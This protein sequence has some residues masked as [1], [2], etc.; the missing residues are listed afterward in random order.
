MYITDLSLKNF[1]NYKNTALSFSKKFNII[2]GMNAQGKTNIIE[3]IYLCASGRS[4]RTS[5]DYEL[6]NIN[7]DKFGVYVS[8]TRKNRYTNISM[9]YEKGKKKSIKIN[10]IP[11]KKIG[12]LMGNMIAVMF[13]P[14]DIFI[15]KDGPSQRRR[16]I[17]ITISQLRP[18]YFYNLQQC[19]K[20]LIQRNM[21]LKEIQYNKSLIETLDIWD[22][23]LSNVAASI[24]NVRNEFINR[25][26]Q[27]AKEIH[28]KITNKNEDFDIEYKPSF[29]IE[30][31]G[32][33]EIKKNLTTELLNIRERELKRCVT[34]VGPHRDDY[35]MGLDGLDLKIYGSQGQQRTAV[36]S[37]KLAEIEIIKDEI[38]ENPILLL[39]DVMSELD[40]T[41][42]KFLIKNI[43]DIQTFI[44]C[45]EID[46][47]FS[48]HKRFS[49]FIHVADDL[50]VI[51]DEF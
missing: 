25:L 51:K 21:L 49:T 28:F 30:D 41:R 14:E 10:D 9:E 37:I 38:G 29:K 23:K 18:S 16:L 15:V 39:D 7:K 31:F 17:D 6:I 48:E 35:L 43:E 13:S 8:V 19:N 27:K 20:I 24:I 4:H 36:L 33:K 40:S 2:Y 1:R 50:A 44:T 3:A 11:A 5:R 32:V 42:R 45:T 46:P 47:L 12:D 22:E 34:L 26:S